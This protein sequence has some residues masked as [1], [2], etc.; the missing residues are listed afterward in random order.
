STVMTETIQ[1]SGHDEA[2]ENALADNLRVD[3]LA[4]IGQALERSVLSLLHYMVHCGIAH[5]LQC[6]QRI[7]DRVLTNLECPER[8][9]DGRGHLMDAETQRIRA[10]IRQLVRVGHV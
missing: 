1:R 10:E 9:L 4:E 8:G 2:F 5:P 7:I 3:P 6:R